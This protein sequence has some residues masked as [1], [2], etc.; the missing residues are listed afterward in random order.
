MNEF[1]RQPQMPEAYAARL[2]AARASRSMQGERRIITMLFCDV[3]DSVAMAGQLDPEEWAEIMDDAFD[4]MIAPIYAYEGT[5]ARL[6]GDGFLAFFGAPITHED[7]PQRAILAGLDIVIGIRPFRQQIK[8]EY[9]FDFN[10]R[11]GINT[12][13]VV[14]GEI[15][16]DLALEYTAMGDA[17]N[18]ASRMESTAAPG[19]VQITESTYRLVAPLFDVW[20]LD[21]LEVKGKDRPV[22]A[23]RVLGKLLQPGRVRG[24]K[25]IDVPMVG[26]TGECEQLKQILAEVRQG[27]GQIACL[28]GE[29]GLG[30]SRIIAE[31]HQEWRATQPPPGE[32]TAWQRW[33]YME[34]VSYG[35]AQPYGMIKHQVQQA[36]N[37]RD[38]DPP[39]AVRTRL[40]QVVTFYPDSVRER[41]LKM[42]AT[43][44]GVAPAAGDDDSTIPE[45]N[46]LQPEGE[47]FKRELFSLLLEATQ[48]QVGETPT[49]YVFDD[50]HWCDP[51]SVAVIQHIFQLAESHPVLFL[52]AMRPERD[53]PGW[54]IKRTAES[55]HPDRYTEIALQPL[56]AEDS[57]TLVNSL[58]AITNL[59]PT[60]HQVI[61][62]KT[63][64]NPFFIEEVVRALVDSDAVVRDENGLSWRP[65]PAAKQIAIP[66]NVLA[67]LASRIDRLERDT[68][69]TLQL[70]S[71]IGRS[72]YHCV[73]ETVADKA[74]ALNEH[75]ERLEQ[76]D[77]IYETSRLPELEYTFR[78]ALTRDAAYKSILHR[79][80]RQF[81]RRVGEA[82]EA[83]F[84]ERLEEEAPRLAHHFQEARDFDK[85]LKY[86]TTAGD[87]ATRLYANTEAIEHYGRALAIARDAGSNE[88][89]LYL[90]TRYGRTLEQCGLYDEALA[91]YLE[92][93]ALAHERADRALELAALIPQATIYATLTTRQDGRKGEELS[94]RA[95]ALAQALPDRRAEAKAYWNLMMIHTYATQDLPQAIAYG[96]QSVAIAR[97][98]NLREELAFA[99]HDITRAYFLTARAGEAQATQAEAHRLWRELGNMPMLADSLG[100]MAQGMHMMGRFDEAIELAQ[101]G[102]R[103]SESIGNPWGQAF[104]SYTLGILYGER[105]EITESITTLRT[106]ASLAQQASFAGP[107][108]Y[109]PVVLTWIYGL[110]GDIDYG[111]HLAEQLLAESDLPPGLSLATLLW[112]AQQLF[113][114]GDAAGAG[115]L[116]QELDG[117]IL[118]EEVDIYFSPYVIGFA[119]Q[120][121]LA[122]RH[123][124]RALALVEST[125]AEIRPSQICLF[126]PDLLHVQ[127][128]ALLAL[129][130]AEA[131]YAALLEARAEATKQ[132]SRRSLWPIL[133]TLIRVEQEQ[134]N[135]AAAAA[136]RQ[137]AQAVVTYIAGHIDD[138]RLHS[139]FLSLPDVQAIMQ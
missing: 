17:I 106:S 79:Q 60:L 99:L 62:Q 68:R 49:V 75:L 18:L 46:L 47:A 128:R 43:L 63:E 105:G 25:G 23:Y 52:C 101:E 130:Q 134:G 11:V 95:L 9:G 71:V 45:D 73:L 118:T 112:R 92:I 24:I 42:F 35:A 48:S 78:H 138:P 74:T 137:E 37:I 54:Q 127:G 132:V 85:A 125:I 97:R 87:T 39:D 88:Q 44:L 90:C 82:M 69:Q 33:S 94:M 38:T 30:K 76:L 133:A 1:R 28:I 122:N 56:T 20:E 34:A 100:T 57:S 84:P 51:A 126:L 32:T 107:P 53:A 121:A 59:P 7:D 8:R 114:K 131:G 65:V 13:P 115:E 120:V 135:T 12:G 86:Y 119:G 27:R 70:A 55:R 116:L 36:G 136:H 113:F 6:M 102:L 110:L 129:G 77:L 29:A 21:D 89:L 96:E 4:Y 10:V 15:G 139:A 108:V 16:S 61:L 123:F 2:R 5:V 19:T 80:R 93:E 41:L 103:V 91:H 50:C 104:N 83:L 14:V 98:H 81:H 64:G 66:D 26:R 67:L 3:S 117:S 22:R 40:A 72:F 124:E 111:V 109:V 31:L 58:L